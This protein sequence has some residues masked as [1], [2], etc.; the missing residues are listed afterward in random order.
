MVPVNV[1]LK[2][3]LSTN[4]FTYKLCCLQFLLSPCLKLCVV[5]DFLKVEDVCNSLCSPPF[6]VF[7]ERTHRAVN[8]YLKPPSAARSGVAWCYVTDQCGV[9]N[10]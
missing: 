3:L 6:L 1:G 9:L 7:W 4:R 2:G 5:E 8:R 10:L